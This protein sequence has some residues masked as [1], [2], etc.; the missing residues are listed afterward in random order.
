[1][2]NG[3]TTIYNNDDANL[4]E[5]LGDNKTNINFQNQER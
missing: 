4:H 3:N 1:M 2:E 5:V